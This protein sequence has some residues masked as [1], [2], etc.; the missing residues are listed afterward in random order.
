[1]GDNAGEGSG[2]L[3]SVSREGNVDARWIE[4]DSISEAERVME[5]GSSMIAVSRQAEEIFIVSDNAAGGIQLS[6]TTEAG[7]WSNPMELISG[8]TPSDIEL[9]VRGDSKLMLGWIRNG[10]VSDV[11]VASWDTGNGDWELL[12]R[13]VYQG[14]DRISGLQLISEVGNSVQVLF[15]EAGDSVSIR[16]FSVALSDAPV[17]ESLEFSESGELGFV[18]QLSPGEI[19]RLEG[20][21]D[22]LNWEALVEAQVNETPWRVT[23]SKNNTRD[24]QFYR[25]V[26]GNP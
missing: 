3:V 13:L 23:D 11:E 14:D 20:S 22:L 26:R 25:V 4:S 24:W 1:M 5:S 7:G 2:V 19:Y 17:I 12:P 16:Q 9:R 15:K 21:P 8:V 10:A 6:D 18:V